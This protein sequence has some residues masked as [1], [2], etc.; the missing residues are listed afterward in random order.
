MKKTKIKK[1]RLTSVLFYLLAICLITFAIGFI[2]FSFYHNNESFDR[3]SFF[4]GLL[5]G[6]IAQ[7]VDGALGMAYGVTAT[8]LLLSN[9]VSPALATASVHISEIFTTGAS[10]LS[11]WK[12]GNVNN[13]LFRSLVIPGVIGGV[14]GVF[15]ITSI[16]AK[17]IRP[18]IASYLLIMGFYIFV[19]A[20]KKINFNNIVKR[21]KV[22][23][24]ALV[25]GFVDSVG[26]G[27]W[28]PVVT[29]TLLGSGHEPRRTIGTVNASE[30]FITVATGFS[31]I[32]LIGISYWEIVAGLIISGMI[33]AP[34]AAKILSKIPVKPLMA[35]VGCLIIFLSAHSIY[36]SLF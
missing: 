7:C 16:D 19:K 22:M 21:K 18:I 8:T 26:G 35:F 3:N 23:P 29:T 27:G 34:F 6:A 20:F 25:G 1:E 33:V 9:G 15:V 2:L 11:H 32:L 14:L 36:K 10:G 4:Y 17:V 24:L 13:K 31:F 30:F 12:M 5:I 28:G